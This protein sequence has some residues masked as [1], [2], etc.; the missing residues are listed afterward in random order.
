LATLTQAADIK[1]PEPQKTGGMPLME[2]LNA[3]QTQR[4][5]SAKPLSE[6][7]LANLLWAAFGINRDNGKRTAPSARNTQE[8]SIYVALPSGL[9]LYQAKSNTLEQISEQDIRALV[10]RQAFV[11]TAPVGLIY[12]SDYDI[13]KGESEFYSATDTGYISQN[14]YLF[15]ASAGMNTVVLGSV[16]KPALQTAMK[17]KPSQHVILTQPVGFPPDAPGGK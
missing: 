2:A 6:Q 3:R 17:L 14:V 16:D 8:I 15:C 9:Y 7:Q 5:F 4:T 13:I 1:L 10:G 11:K 12:V